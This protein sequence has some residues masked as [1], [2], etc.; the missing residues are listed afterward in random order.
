MPEAFHREP[1]TGKDGRGREPVTYHFGQE[2]V[3]RSQEPLEYHL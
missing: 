2:P 3:A 1:F